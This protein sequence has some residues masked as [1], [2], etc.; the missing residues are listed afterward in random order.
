MTFLFTEYFFLL[1]YF[2]ISLFLSFVIF[3]L[4]V[5]F[6]VQHPYPEKLSPY[7]CGF[8][9]F[10]DARNEFDVRFYLVA[11]LFLV[12]DLEATFLFPWALCLGKLSS[13]SFWIMFDFF[14]ELLFGFFYIW[15]VGALDWE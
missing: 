7:E 6:A 3:G 9:P 14:I 2:L 5:L 10:E 13:S 1:T 11:I 15:K 12:F 4:S 8:S